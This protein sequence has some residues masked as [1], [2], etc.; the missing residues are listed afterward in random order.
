LGGL[1]L[2]ISHHSQSREIYKKLGLTSPVTIPLNTCGKNIETGIR[3]HLKRHFE[4]CTECVPSE[5]VEF[6][7]IHHP[8]IAPMLTQS[9][10]YNPFSNTTENKNSDDP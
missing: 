3:D 1:Y 6:G 9:T 7:N 2:Y 5:D 10:K 4:Y 8:K